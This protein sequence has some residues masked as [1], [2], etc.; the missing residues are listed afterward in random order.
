MARRLDYNIAFDAPAEK[1]Y[2]DFASL[3]YWDTLMDA[4]RWLTPMSEIRH[5]KSDETGVDVV[6]KQNLPRMYLPPVAQSVMLVDM[7]ITR[8]QHFDPFDHTANGAKGT[9]GASIPAGPGSFSGVYF[10]T[11]T[12]TETGSQLRLSSTCRVYIPFIGGKLEELILHHITEL[13][14]AEEAFMA[15]WISKHH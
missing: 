3:E 12:E 13:F 6:L 8:V 7:I 2:Q 10:L 9:Y 11:E 15:D 5:F 14:A 4:Y 1:I